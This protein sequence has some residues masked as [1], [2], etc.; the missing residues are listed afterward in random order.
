M[1]RVTI[2][3][4]AGKKEVMRRGDSAFARAWPAALQLVLLALQ[5]EFTGNRS[6][7]L[8]EI[9][10]R[11]RVWTRDWELHHCD[12]FE[13]GKGFVRLAA[14]YAGGTMSCTAATII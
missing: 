9:P 6:G 4:I 8:G 3:G 11:I 12:R 10:Q 1:N 2:T 7:K 5:P 14:R 13:R